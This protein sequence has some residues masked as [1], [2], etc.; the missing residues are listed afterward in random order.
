MNV[1][2]AMSATL[3]AW[4]VGRSM[5]FGLNWNIF[6]LH[7]FDA[8][9]WYNL[10]PIRWRIPA[11][12]VKYSPVIVAICTIPCLLFDNVI[13]HCCAVVMLVSEHCYI[14]MFQVRP[15]YNLIVWCC[16][17]ILINMI[18]FYIITAQSNTYFQLVGNITCLIKTIF[19]IWY[20]IIEIQLK[21]NVVRKIEYQI[22]QPRLSP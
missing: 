15:A 6:Y 20:L 19:H 17:N 2:F 8:D 14:P 18:L 1:W 12:L 9:S 13:I 10:T 4:I 7:R 22:R 5:A 11:I 21:N 16:L 3:W